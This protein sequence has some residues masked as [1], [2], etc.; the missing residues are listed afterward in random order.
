VRLSEK[1]IEFLERLRELVDA[2][3]LWIERTQKQPLRFVLR[4][5][6]GSRVEDRFGLTRQG[7]RWRFKR[8]FNDLY[9]ESFAVLIFIE[10]QL[11]AQFRQDALIIAHER[12]MLR[13]KALQNH[14]FRE[15][16]SYRGKDQD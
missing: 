2:D 13:Q 15:A 8:L 5:N 7:V 9:V 10:K 1:D 14:S 11:G 6:Y 16:N 3:V 12:F 4:G